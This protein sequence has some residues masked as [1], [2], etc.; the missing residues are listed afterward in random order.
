MTLPARFPSVDE[1]RDEMV[2]NAPATPAP[3]FVLRGLPGSGKTFVAALTV[4]RCVLTGRPAEVVSADHFLTD[5]A[6]NYRFDPS[7]LPDA[8]AAC[9]H[10]FVTAV[11]ACPPTTVVIVD[12]TNLTAAEYAPYTAVGAAFG[13]PTFLVTV[14]VSPVAAFARQTHGVPQET[15]G[16][17]VAR[18]RGE[19]VPSFVRHVVVGNSG[20]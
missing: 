5:A 19:M 10:R 12:N 20:R 2:S 8:H 4:A 7:R 16:R 13:R 18:Q 17:M 15:F 9:L 6:G 14:D 1:F 3:V 11:T